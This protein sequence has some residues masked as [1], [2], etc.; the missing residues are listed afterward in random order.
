VKREQLLQR[1]DTAWTAFNESFAG[2]SAE[3][4]TEPG[5]VD[6]WSVKDILAHV[7]T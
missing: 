1:I 2:L 6:N 7:T 3:R 4:L 5:V